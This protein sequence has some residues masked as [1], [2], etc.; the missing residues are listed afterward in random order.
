MWWLYREVLCG[1][2]STLWL[3]HGTVVVSSLLA[4]PWDPEALLQKG[5]EHEVAGL[6]LQ[7]EKHMK[8]VMVCSTALDL[9]GTLVTL[10]LPSVADFVT[11][12]TQCTLYIVPCQHSLQ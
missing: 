2:N 6:W 7:K 4:I 12:Q 1:G 5:F 10:F 3:H 11:K 8:V 9:L